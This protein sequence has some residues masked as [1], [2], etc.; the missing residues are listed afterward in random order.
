MG[1]TLG[2]R[3]P[4]CTKR[5]GEADPFVDRIK[6]VES[7][8]VVGSGSVAMQSK[9]KVVPRGKQKPSLLEAKY[10]IIQENY[11]SDNT[12]SEL[13]ETQASFSVAKRRR[14]QVKIPNVYFEKSQH[15]RLKDQNDLLTRFQALLSQPP[16]ANIVV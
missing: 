7:G 1:E 11:S 3:D 6:F 5:Q 4:K 14:E 15:E 10:R 2:R 12:D 9:D 8:S 13:G 16:K